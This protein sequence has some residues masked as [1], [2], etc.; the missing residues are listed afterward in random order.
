MSQHV[1]TL[2]REVQELLRLH[3]RML[4]SARMRHQAMAARQVESLERL[5]THE[6]ALAQAVQEVER[7]RQITMLRVGVEFG[8]QPRQM[9][10]VN[11]EQLAT[12]LA[13][14]DRRELLEAH[15]RLREVVEEIRMANSAMT[16]LA[17]RCL[18]WF[19]ELLNVLLG[20]TGPQ[21]GYTSRG[22]AAALSS[23]GA[24]GVVDIQI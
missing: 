24:R 1:K 4:E 7:R 19:E 5:M 21:G 18:P 16:M 6:L 10:G 8:R 20:E 17:Q 15:S 14:S 3:E 2:V 13:P 22:Q 9:G 23:S 11:I 12:W